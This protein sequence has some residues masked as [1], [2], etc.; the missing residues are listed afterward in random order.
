MFSSDKVGLPARGDDEFRPFGDSRDVRYWVVRRGL[1]M[2]PTSDQGCPT[3]RQAIYSGAYQSR[4]LPCSIK[5]H[6]HL[7]RCGICGSNWEIGERAAW[8]IAP[9]DAAAIRNDDDRLVALRARLA[10]EGFRSDAYDLGDAENPSETYVLRD[11]NGT[12]VTFYAERGHENSLTVMPT[13]EEGSQELVRRLR[14]D[15]TTRR[16]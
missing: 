11:R 4:E 16:L 2:K 10:A 6:A 15:L 7:Y 1:Q 12:W 13:F 8:V 14:E 5:R 9:D 3:C